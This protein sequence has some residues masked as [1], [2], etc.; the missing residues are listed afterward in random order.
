MTGAVLNA[1]AMCVYSFLIL[2]LNLSLPKALRP[3][4]WRV[5][6]VGVGGG[7]VW[8]VYDFYHIEDMGLKYSHIKSK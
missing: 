1:G 7:V 8:W 3:N 2:G 5:G 4:W 6:I